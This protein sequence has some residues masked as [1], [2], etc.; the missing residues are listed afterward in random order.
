ML[1][2]QIAF[3]FTTFMPNDMGL[4][5]LISLLFIMSL[6]LT[7]MECPFLRMHL[8]YYIISHYINILHFNL[9]DNAIHPNPKTE[10][11]ILNSCSHGYVII[12]K[13]AELPASPGKT[14]LYLAQFSCEAC[15][16]N[17]NVKSKY[18]EQ[19]VF[20]AIGVTPFPWEMFLFFIK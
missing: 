8:T 5:S 18:I 1:L 15:I 11:M 3:L 16:I 9:Q 13:L 14:F 17:F 20:Y 19:S 4:L 10:W 12:N 6:M 2:Y 7:M